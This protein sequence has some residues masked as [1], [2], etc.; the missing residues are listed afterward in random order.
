[1]IDVDFDNDDLVALEAAVLDA[2]NLM[3]ASQDLRPRVLEQARMSAT[4]KKRNKI[5]AVSFATLVFLC[6]ALLG[7]SDVGRQMVNAVAEDSRTE[8]APSFI[9]SDDL[10]ASA[11]AGWEGPV[12]TREWSLVDA[13]TKLQCNRRRM[14]RRGM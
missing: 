8:L 7:S 11:Y 5:F 13:F 4:Q 3:H 10:I 14:L 1:V 6:S 2:G 9:S 12:A